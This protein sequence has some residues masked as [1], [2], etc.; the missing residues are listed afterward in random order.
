MKQNFS[1][2]EILEAVNLLLEPKSKKKL[3]NK[4]K[5]LPADTER[6]ISQAENYI[7]KR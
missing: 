4:N 5:I 3:E 2:D 6:I 1:I 7:K